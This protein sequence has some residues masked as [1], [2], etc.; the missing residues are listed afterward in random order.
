MN[1]T[2]SRYKVDTPFAMADAY[3]LSHWFQF[4]EGTTMVYSNITCRY[5]RRNN[6][7]VVSYGIRSAIRK[8]EEMFD[9]LFFYDDEDLAVYKFDRFYT[10]FFGKSN[11]EANEKV[12]TLHQL[13]Y[14]PLSYA[15]VPEGDLV[16][17]GSPLFV[18]YNTHADCYWLTNFVETFL[19]AE[20]W[21]SIT[22]ATTALQYR[23]TFEKYA[24]LTMSEENM[25]FVD[26]Q[27]HDFSFRGL[28]S[29]EVAMKSGSAHLLFFRGTDTCPAVQYIEHEFDLPKD[30]SFVI[31]GSVPAT[32][33]AVMS[34]GTKESELETYRR[35]IT[36]I[37][38]MGVVS[39]VSDTY[40][41]W[42]VITEYLP[43]LKDDILAREGKV[44]IRPDSSKK[45]P[46]E[47]IVGDPEA[48]EGSPEYKGLVECLYEIFGGKVNQK[49]YKELD[50]HIGC[51]YGD[52]I[53]PQFQKLILKGLAE[54]GFASSNVV[55][56]IGSYTYQYVTRDT[57][58]FAIKATYVEIDG[59]PREIFKDPKTDSGIKKSA[60]G[61][62][63]PVKNEQG[64][65]TLRTYDKNSET[66]GE[67]Y[68]ADWNSLETYN[69]GLYPLLRTNWVDLVNRAKNSVKISMEVS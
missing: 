26:W 61:L 42:K 34:A 16:E 17:I 67:D 53:T 45:T 19:S 50:E 65:W 10:K 37:Y 49:G 36:D 29:V 60:K 69:T 52:S 54:K 66:F 20:I 35:L 63:L 55:L 8:L 40:D 30:D 62:V 22:S 68:T 38:P 51:I 28:P 47:I 31:A 32:E 39:I 7:Y 18:V 24:E 13:G 48:P 41:F 2:N 33:H 23:Q 64:I 59:E 4:P 14:L 21:H 25:W 9:E 46:V 1:L 5:S 11:P 56:G 58:G 44:V 15:W 27:G 6:P 43:E 57:E 12:R 3:K